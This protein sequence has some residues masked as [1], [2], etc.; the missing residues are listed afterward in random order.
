MVTVAKRPGIQ[1]QN[2]RLIAEN[3]DKKR[4][5]VVS[6][7]YQLSVV[8]VQIVAPALLGYFLR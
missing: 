7:R 1:R 8:S 5:D 2:R 6:P 3:R 4:K